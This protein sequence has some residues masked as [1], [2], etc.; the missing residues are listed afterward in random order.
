MGNPPGCRRLPAPQTGLSSAEHAQHKWN[1]LH[2]PRTSAMPADCHSPLSFLL[3]GA[4]CHSQRS[5]LLLWLQEPVVQSHDARK[6][7]WRCQ[8]IGRELEFFGWNGCLNPSTRPMSPYV[9]QNARHILRLLRDVNLLARSPCHIAFCFR[10]KP[11][12]RT[13]TKWGFL[14]SKLRCM[15]TPRAVRSTVPLMP[16][17]WRP[18]GGPG[19]GLGRAGNP[20]ETPPEHNICRASSGGSG[21]ELWARAGRS[22]RTASACAG[23]NGAN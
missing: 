10:K 5:Q 15:R 12:G 9:L 14:S 3:L 23:S 8:E 16:E 4:D 6:G 13:H 1:Y 11:S 17:P 20:L 7:R 19:P 2:P 22:R 21:A 18:L